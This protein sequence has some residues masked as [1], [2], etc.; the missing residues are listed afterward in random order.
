MFKKVGV[1][2]VGSLAAVGGTAQAEGIDVAAVT[3]YLSGDVTT[4]IVAVGGALILLAVTA[5]G[6]KWIKGMIFG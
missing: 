5:V 6:F 3:G 4:A 1:A 2:L